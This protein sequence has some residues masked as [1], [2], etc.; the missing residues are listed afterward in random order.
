[1][2]NAVNFVPL[3]FS[4]SCGETNKKVQKSEKNAAEPPAGITGRILPSYNKRHT[5][6][7]RKRPFYYPLKNFMQHPASSANPKRKPKSRIIR[8]IVPKR[9][10]ESGLSALHPHPARK[11]G[12]L[13]EGL[14]TI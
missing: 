3:H 10:H 6:G 5:N 12:N 8:Q 13:T 9:T 2:R 14:L 1:M 7:K 11:Y 4:V